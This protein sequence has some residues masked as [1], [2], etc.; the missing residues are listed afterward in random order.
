[1]FAGLYYKCS[2]SIIVLDT[3]SSSEDINVHFRVQ[4]F[5][6]LKQNGLPLEK[7]YIF[8]NDLP[9]FESYNLQENDNFRTQQGQC[10]DWSLMLGYLFVKEFDCEDVPIAEDET[11]V[12]FF[13]SFVTATVQQSEVPPE[14][15]T[16][17]FLER[18]ASFYVG[19]VEYAE[20]LKSYVDVQRE[21][22]LFGGKM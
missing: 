14:N 6:L 15:S 9:G 11:N 7:I 5:N 17:T 13:E 21:I 2:K 4:L 1:V 19:L 18:V 16:V 12:N 3:K 20:D 10:Q 22:G 8:P